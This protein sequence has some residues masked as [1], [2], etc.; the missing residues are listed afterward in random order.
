M[1]E[2]YCPFID[3]HSESWKNGSCSYSDS[4]RE[5]VLILGNSQLTLERYKPGKGG[6]VSWYDMTRPEGEEF[7]VQYKWFADEWGNP[8]DFMLGVN[9]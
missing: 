8:K 4:L 5:G 1:S 2:S 9:D 3:T 6:F 7:V